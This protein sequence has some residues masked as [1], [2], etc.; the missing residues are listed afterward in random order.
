M[1]CIRSTVYSVM[2]GVPLNNGDMSLWEYQ[3]RRLGRGT[4]AIDA[5]Y[6]TIKDL[7]ASDS[8]YLNVFVHPDLFSKLP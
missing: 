4:R 8:D 2:A 5:V 1:L 6:E 3:M 7:E